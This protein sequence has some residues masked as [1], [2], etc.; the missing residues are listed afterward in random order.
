ME[1]RV[2]DPAGFRDMCLNIVIV[3]VG[4]RS[5][6]K[7]VLSPYKIIRAGTLTSPLGEVKSETCILVH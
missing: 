4:V 1:C 6:S 7:T 3:L 5:V 2:R